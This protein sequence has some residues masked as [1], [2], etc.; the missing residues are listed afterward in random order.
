MTAGN[1]SASCSASTCLF[2][3]AVQLTPFVEEIMPINPAAGEFFFQFG[4][5]QITSNTEIQKVIVG[6]LQ[7]NSN[8]VW[9]TFSWLYRSHLRSTIELSHVAGE[10]DLVSYL[11]PG[12]P[13]YSLR[14]VQTSYFT[15]KNFT[16]RVVAKINSISSQRSGKFG[17]RNLE[18]LFDHLRVYLCSIIMIIEIGFFSANR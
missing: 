14:T 16:Q 9:I 17:N 5:P 3:Y 13:T 2:T 7:C 10:Y 12:F 1:A 11:N 4:V 8:L 6:N 18:Y 15:N